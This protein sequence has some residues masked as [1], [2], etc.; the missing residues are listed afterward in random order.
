[1]KDI[2]N[3]K[4]KPKQ[5]ALWCL[6]QAGYIIKA[7]ETLVAIDPYL[8]DSVGRIAPQLRRSAPVPLSPKRL[9]VDIFI[10]THDHLDHLDPE[11][12]EGYRYKKQTLFV[13]PRLACKKLLTLGIPMENIRQID[14]GETKIISGVEI[15]GVYAIPNEPKV[16][17]T[18]GYKMVFKN[19]RSVYH[20][21]DTGFSQL[22]LD[23][24]P[25]AEVALLC[26]NGKWGNL[27]AT[28]AARLAAK[29]NPKVAIPNHYDIMTLNSE[30]PQTFEYLLRYVNPDIDVKVLSLMERFVW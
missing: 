3:Y 19:R 26:I 21:S 8:S 25:H 6:G 29:V 28:E 27:N 30:N 20:S 12:I 10:V 7:A 9:K 22:L 11:T 4:L 23:C 14:T 13:A 15:T 2:L 5:A 18:A 24:A 17:D 16:V 1:M